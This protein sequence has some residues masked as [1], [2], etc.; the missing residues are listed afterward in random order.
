MITPY[1]FKRIPL[2]LIDISDNRIRRQ[3]PDRVETLA[4]D[5]AVNG[6]LQPIVVV[7]EENGRFS[8]DDG[9]I[10]IAAIRLNKGDDI[11][12]RVTSVAWLKPEHRRLREIMTNLNREDY[13]AL[14][15]CEAL[16]ELKRVYE[17]LY[18]ETRKG[19]DKG[20]QHTG[21][22]KRQTE[23]FSFSQTAAEAT[24]LSDRA[25]RLAI[26]I[27]NG[28]TLVAKERLRGTWIERKQTEIRALSEASPNIQSAVLDLL[29]SD[30]PQAGSVADAIAFAEGR[31]LDSPSEKTYRAVIDKW[32]RFELRQ[33]RAF[34]TSYR[35]EIVRILTEEGAI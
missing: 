16:A 6:Q 9:A 21:G 8:L 29:L 28:L 12:A 25:I 24:G 3:R 5:I 11:D 22:K 19:G 33:K 14:E 35:D 4:K 7:E 15:R 30:P 26:A 2:Y 34:V 27:W 18:P 1:E 31:K 13:T 17:E 20:N 23:I 10:R 32:A